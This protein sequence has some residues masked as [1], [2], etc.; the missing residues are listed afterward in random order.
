MPVTLPLPLPLF[1]SA[2]VLLFLSPSLQPT[3]SVSLSRSVSRRAVTCSFTHTVSTPQASTPSSVTPVSHR[4]PSL[5]TY[6][7]ADDHSST[8]PPVRTRPLSSARGD[9]RLDSNLIH[10]LQ[11]WSHAHGTPQNVASTHHLVRGTTADAAAHRGGDGAARRLHRVGSG[12]ASRGGRL[13][14]DHAVHASGVLSPP[15]SPPDLSSSLAYAQDG[16]THD[17]DTSSGGTTA[18]GEPC[19]GSTPPH[20]SQLVLLAPVLSFFRQR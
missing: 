3:W 19:V 8:A 10:P 12:P 17:W 2:V 6:Y 11:R 16:I 15:S 20:E 7:P 1:T 14:A 18:C 4:L 9:I 13:D 5:S